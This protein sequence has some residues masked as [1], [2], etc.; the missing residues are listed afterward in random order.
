MHTPMGSKADLHVHSKYSDRPSEWFLRRIGAPECFVEPRAIYDRAREHGMDFVTISDHN[1]IRGALEI[2]HLPGTFLSAEV[3]TY[4]PENGCKIHCLV[5]GIREDQFRIIQELRANIYELAKFLREEEIVHSIAHPL[6]RVNDRLMIDQ[7]EKLI[8]MFRRFEG[9]NGTRDRRAAELTRAVLDHLTPELIARMADRHDI[10]PIGPDPHRKVYTGGSDDHSGAYTGAAHTVTPYAADVAEFLAHLQHGD[11]QPGGS[12]GG[13]VMLGHCLYHIGYSYYRERLLGDGKPT[14]VGEIFKRLLEPPARPRPAAPA[15]RQ[16]LFGWVTAYARSRAMKRLSDVERVVV[17]EFQSLFRGEV[18]A[19]PASHPAA[20][21]RTFDVACRISHALSFSFLKKFQEHAAHGRLIDSIQT[22]A[23]LA[24]VAL[25]IAPYLGAFS[26]QHKDEAFHR[27]VAAYFPAA[28]HLQRRSERKAWVTDTY[29]DVNGVSRTIQKMGEVAHTLGRK[30]TVLTCLDAA[31]D[32][33]GIDLCNFRPVGTFELPEY[34]GQA[35]SF[36][37]FLEVIEYLER[38]RMDEVI[39]STPGPLGLNALAAARLLN[40]RT[41][42]IYHTDFPL[43]VRYLTE[44]ES[45]VALTWKYMLWFYD[46]MDVIY[47]PSEYYRKH[48]AQNGFDPAKLRV[49]VRGV[50]LEQFSP[51]KRDEQFWS[52]HGLP[53][54][55]T[56]AYV[57]RV[58]VE[59]NL[60]LALEAFQQLVARGARV[61]FAIVGD[62]PALKDLRRRFAGPRVCFTGFLEGDELSAAYASSDVFVFPSTFDTFGNAVL[63]AHASGLPAIVADRGGPPDIVRPYGS[64]I[65]VDVAQPGA[66]AQAMQQLANS[67]ELRAE[68][69]KGALRCAAE[70]SWEE[71]VEAFWNPAEV[72]DY[73]QRSA[74]FRQSQP[75]P[76][77]SVMSLETA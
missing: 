75:D 72:D 57:G 56:F 71:V 51:E 18:D 70:S 66:L 37:P 20:D 65:V 68:M 17:G 11:H 19:A 44:D 10:E 29:T 77:A 8:L 4:F 1:D 16:R 38:Q 25:S 6:F 58:S 45:L 41:V 27:A 12:P 43:L 14:L 69:R 7:V 39:I 5:T 49:M 67:A 50:D 55:L 53:P 3:T 48:L 60:P 35:L 74:A 15:L 54:G 47:A 42:G 61:N 34:Q 40:L 26:T 31:P 32:A 21:R 28:R 2:A 36:P 73:A 33:P 46:Q 9:I 30:M 24:P 62:G 23:A 64:G 59:K 63:E 22:L 13:S 76:A 52:R